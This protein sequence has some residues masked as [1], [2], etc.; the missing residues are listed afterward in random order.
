MNI[1]LVP[2]AYTEKK[3]QSLKSNGDMICVLPRI[4]GLGLKLNCCKILLPKRLMTTQHSIKQP[5]N[6]E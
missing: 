3:K 5:S 2:Y 4:T 1:A 6:L